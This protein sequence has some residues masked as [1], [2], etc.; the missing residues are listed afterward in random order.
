[1]SDPSSPAGVVRS[2]WPSMTSGGG[3]ASAITS[4][5]VGH[6]LVAVDDD[7][8]LGRRI[9]GRRAATRRPA[10]A[11]VRTASRSRSAARTS[12][13]AEGSMRDMI[14][15]MSLSPRPLTLTTRTASR[16]ELADQLRQRRDRVGRLERR[17]DALAARQQR[18]GR[19][20]LGVADPEV[21]RAPGRPQVRVLGPTPG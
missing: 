5:R 11:G 14:V 9:G 20:R 7:D 12:S 4:G 3:G 21:A 16:P 15:C 18:R 19:Q 17:D 10:R 8:V 13:S 1:M 6:E 2:S